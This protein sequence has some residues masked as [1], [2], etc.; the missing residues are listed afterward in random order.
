[1]TWY[2]G[3]GARIERRAKRTRRRTSQDFSTTYVE[4]L[5]R[6]QVIQNELI[7]GFS[8]KHWSSDKLPE[9]FLDSHCQKRKSEEPSAQETGRAREDG[10][11]HL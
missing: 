9:L 7:Q 1:M 6:R 5:C 4:S 2:L 8:L 3:R 11:F 10:P